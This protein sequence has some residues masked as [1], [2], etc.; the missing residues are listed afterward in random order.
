MENIYLSI[1][2]NSQKDRIDKYLWEILWLSRNF[3]SRLIESDYIYIL[4]PNHKTNDIENIPKKSIKKSYIPQKWDLIYISQM[5]R[6]ENE[7]I[8]KDSPKI[9]IKILFSNAEDIHKS[10]YLI[11]YKPKWVLS[12]P[13]SI[14]DIQKP[15]ITW[16]LYHQFG[17][18]PWIWNFIRSWLIHRLDKDTDGIMVVAL[19]EI[20]LQHFQKLFYQKS[21]AETIT[22]KEDIPLH[23]YYKATS[24]ITDKW[25][26]FI[27][28]I[29]IQLPYII[30][31]PVIPKIPHYDRN[32]LWIT[33]ITKIQIHDN[34]KY[35]DIYI[36]IL[37][38]KTHQIR[39]HLSNHGL[40]I[41]WDYLYNPQKH[42]ETMQLT[43]YKLER[44]D[45][46]NNIQ[47]I[48]L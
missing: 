9:D 25:Q 23:K 41:L 14:R 21:I 26:K 45:L 33:K 12:H 13:N 31:E 16:R 4:T 15:S 22:Q 8:L 37:T 34:K 6:F 29:S 35:A 40:P 7:W 24:L 18:L 30:S 46:N 17:N 42:P 5:R 32:N 28:N 19:T 48:E 11:I 27:N 44:K 10:D 36:E 3:I 20:W 2:L 47:K 39:Y 1:Y 38:W 43:A